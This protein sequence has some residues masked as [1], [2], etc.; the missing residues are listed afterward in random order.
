MRIGLIGGIFGGGAEL[1]RNVWYTPETILADGLR[2][3]GHEVA[4]L[5]HYEPIPMNR[6]DVVHVHH[7]GFGAVR[8]ACSASRTPFVFTVHSTRR[9]E[10]WVRERALR[11]VLGRADAVIALSEAER[12][13]DEAAYRW[14]GGI[15]RVI[16]NGVDSGM[17]HFAPKPARPSGHRWSVLCVAHLTPLKGHKTL[18][19]AMARLPF[20]AELTLVYH[21]ETILG[22][23][24]RIASELGIASRVKYLGAKNPNELRDLYQ[25]S[26]VFV[27]PSETEAL[28]SVITEA[29]MCGT[30]VVG[31]DV[32]GVREQLG[33]A[34]AIVPPKDADALAAGIRRVV[35]NY[36]AWLARSE[37][38]SRR[39]Q[40]RFS[41]DTMLRRHVELYRET[42]ESGACVRRSLA[43]WPANIAAGTAASLACSLRGNPRLRRARP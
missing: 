12:R 23:L 9:N 19:H 33:D 37:Q 15:H 43:A 13:A 34:G 17:Y 31:T 27:L 4:P 21:H 5:S 22:E 14:R 26:D 42:I 41:I 29:M 6:F 36:P 16:F 10:T 18:L 35:E 1:R 32:G 3:L 24:Q 30:P 28:P 8:A 25:Q 11:F 7:F 38:I 40:D 39:A 20:D 2:R